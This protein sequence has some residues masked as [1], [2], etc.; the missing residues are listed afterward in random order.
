[1]QICNR[2]QASDVHRQLQRGKHLILL[3]SGFLFINFY[4]FIYFIHLVII[5]YIVLFLFRTVLGTK[6]DIIS[7]D[8][9][10]STKY[11][12]TY[13]KIRYGMYIYIYIYI[14]NSQD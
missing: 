1:M 11:P 8:L 7:N 13:K 6:E 12:F 9:E 4:L 2:Y 3:L 5:L 10:L 14:Y